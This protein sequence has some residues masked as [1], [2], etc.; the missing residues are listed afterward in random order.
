MHVAAKAQVAPQPRVREQPAGVDGLGAVGIAGPHLDVHR[1]VLEVGLFGVAPALAVAFEVAAIGVGGMVLPAVVGELVVVPGRDQRHLREQALPQRIAAVGAMQLAIVVEAARARCMAVRAVARQ[2]PGRIVEGDPAPAGHVPGQRIAG[3]FVDRVAEVEQHVGRIVEQGVQG[4]VPA[5]DVVL[6]AHHADAHGRGAV[7]GRRG[8][9]AAVRR[10]A[11]A[12]RGLAQE[13]VVVAGGCTQALDAH[14]QA[15]V[16]G[17]AGMQVAFDHE[18]D[19][20]GIQR[21]L[22]AQRDV[23][24]RG[25]GRAGPQQHAVRARIA[26]GQSLREQPRV[27][28]GRARGGHAEAAGEGQGG[29]RDHQGLQQASSLRVEG[30]A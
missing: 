14:A 18:F 28:G 19:E 22:Q 12:L 5:P 25:A 3:G 20:A 13:A 30:H 10:A 24:A 8:A 29:R 26:R 1:H 7:R 17:G 23:L 21:D 9:G 27:D 15:M 11:P 16:G 4:V 2:R 6:A